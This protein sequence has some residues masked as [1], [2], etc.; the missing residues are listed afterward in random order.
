M[1]DAD[2]V[3][4]VLLVLGARLLVPLTIPKFPLPASLAA[5]IADFM[6]GTAAYQAFAT[7]GLTD[8][9]GYDKALDVYYLS[10][11]YLSTM[12][13]WGNLF[14]F[15]M[16]RLLFYYRLAGGLLFEVIQIRALFLFF[17]NAFEYFFLFYEAVRLR[18]DPRR[19]GRA[20]LIGTAFAVW[21]LIKIPQ[22][23]WIHIAQFETADVKEIIFRE[24]AETAWGAIVAQNI[25][26]FVVL[27]AA[28][29]V[30][31]AVMRW[32]IVTKLPPADWSLS[33]DA[34]GHGSDVGEDEAIAVRQEG[35]RHV[36]DA[37]LFEKIAL[38]SIVTITALRTVPDARAEVL[39]TG[40]AATIVIVAN[41]AISEWLVRHGMQWRSFL[42][43]FSVMAMTNSVIVAGFVVVLPRRGDRLD[44]AVALFSLLLLTLLVTLYDRY[45][46]IYVARIQPRASTRG[47]EA[48]GSLAK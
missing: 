34:D 15:N 6:D 45:R 2:D 20:L 33:F 5:I 37:E 40:V 8:Y 21:V 26:L 31:A 32:F 17:P 47:A 25:A 14:A 16:G 13:N 36:L 48:S 41:T 11:Q 24:P 35:A 1:P 3:V 28:L 27:A 38:V 4:I 18:W 30:V 43:H 7:V 23:Y 9:Q 29:V 22:E 19:M 42:V 44:V 10:I 39:H 46:P 12:R